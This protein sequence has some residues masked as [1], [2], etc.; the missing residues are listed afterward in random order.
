M[1]II[2]YEDLNFETYDKRKINLGKRML[3]LG[4]LL[5]YFVNRAPEVIHASGRLVVNVDG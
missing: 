5:R 1:K 2:F 4:F 3:N